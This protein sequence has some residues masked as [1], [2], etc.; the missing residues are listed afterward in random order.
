MPRGFRGDAV[1][2]YLTKIETALETSA[3]VHSRDLLR[4]APTAL[5]G[6]PRLPQQFNEQVT[7]PPRT[8]HMGDWARDIGNST[9]IA[10]DEVRYQEV[11]SQVNERI[12]RESITTYE[13]MIAKLREMRRTTFALPQAGPRLEFCIHM[14]ESMFPESQRL[15]DE[16]NYE[17]VKFA[18]EALESGFQIVVWNRN[19]ATAVYDENER[20]LTNQEMSM[21]NTIAGCRVAV[22]DRESERQRQIRIS[23]TA[24]RWNGRRRVPDEERRARARAKA[25][26]LLQQIN[27]MNLAITE[28]SDAIRE[29]LRARKEANAFFEATEQRLRDLDR[30]YDN[31]VQ[32]IGYEIRN[33]RHRLRQI[34]SDI[35]NL[36]Y[37]GVKH[38]PGFLSWLYEHL[39]KLD[40]WDDKLLYNGVLNG[41]ALAALARREEHTLLESRTL[42]NTFKQLETFEDITLF[43]RLMADQVGEINGHIT[44]TYNLE[45]I[46][47]ILNS[48]LEDELNLRRQMAKH[49]DLNADAYLKLQERHKAILERVGLLA[50]V[51]ALTYTSENVSQINRRGIDRLVNYTHGPLLG[52]ATGPALSFAPDNHRAFNR[53]TYSKMHM[54]TT[55]SSTGES[56]VVYNVR[57]MS[58]Q[59]SRALMGSEINS[60]ITDADANVFLTRYTHPDLA[61][62]IV[63]GTMGVGINAA[64]GAVHPV[65]GIVSG[66][67]DAS[68]EGVDR[69]QREV[70]MY[71]DVNYIFDS[72]RVATFAVEYGAIV[73]VIIPSS[74]EKI[75]ILSESDRMAR[76]IQELDNRVGAILDN[77][78]D[79]RHERF[80][81]LGE[82]ERPITPNA[83]IDNF[84]FFSE[85][86]YGSLGTSDSGVPDDIDK[87]FI[88]NAVGDVNRRF[89]P[90]SEGDSQ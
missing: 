70:Q 50:Y 21:E 29:M 60:V 13:L 58:A 6:R 87:R 5:T 79:R 12:E 67:A 28:I 78:E 11:A 15:T 83:T 17:M 55:Y 45:K 81:N 14:I 75:V 1:H 59:I 33:F 40:A 23:L 56:N 65:A 31:K 51:S 47:P 9:N 3:E 30:K 53:L 73:Q 77:P 71:E 37:S 64:M 43:L 72:Q 39:S 35:G 76:G 4:G 7:Y 57:E 54:S 42:A 52:D 80:P 85:F 18:Q 48:L 74:G 63:R 2:K 27:G 16:Y 84:A 90:E 32:N 49:T 26:E 66:I 46:N 82:I 36:E 88:N 61:E 10:V 24:M 20:I 69:W 25:A 86:I 34:R 89:I 44:W 62:H 41:D 22:S 38:S 19:D 68:A 8:A